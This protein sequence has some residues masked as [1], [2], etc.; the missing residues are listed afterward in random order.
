MTNGVSSQSYPLRQG[1]CDK[2]TLTKDEKVRG[3]KRHYRQIENMLI[4][5]REGAKLERNCRSHVSHRLS[6]LSL[7]NLTPSC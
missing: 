3:K 6:L 1:N 4:S 5:P 7:T 2:Q